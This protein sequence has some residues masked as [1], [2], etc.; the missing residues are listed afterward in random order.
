[1]NC[2]DVV[3]KTGE[4]LKVEI[5][6]QTPFQV[7]SINGRIG[8][9]GHS[10]SLI[11]KGT[12]D[13]IQREKVSIAGEQIFP[14]GDEFYD[15]DE[16][17]QGA[18]RYSSDFAHYKPR[19]D[20]LLVG[21]CHTPKGTI[22]SARQVTLKVG[23]K[24]KTLNVF[25]NRYWKRSI[26]GSSATEPEPFTE[27][28]LRYENSFGGRGYK[29]NPIGKGIDEIKLK[30]G[31]KV[32]L[33]PNVLRP[34]DQL[35]TLGSKSEPAGFGPIGQMW[36]DRFSKLGSYKGNYLKKRWPW[37][38]EDFDWS[39]FNA[40]PQDMQVEGYLKGDEELYFE[41]LHPEHPQYHSKLPGLRIRC[42]L[43]ESDTENENITHFREVSMN[44]D[45][46]WVDMENEKLVIVWRGVT[47]IK[48]EEYNEIQHIY[49][50]SENIEEQIQSID[51]YRMQFNQKISE[52][53]E[54]VEFEVE[55]PE[56]GEEAADKDIEKEIAKADAQMRASLIE[57][58]IDPD[59]PPPPSKEEKEKET[60]IMKELGIEDEEGEKPLTR[61]IVQEWISLGEGFA[62]EDLSGL[63]LS[64]LDM[65]GIDLKGAIL[66]GVSFKNAN[67]S[68]AKLMD[69]NLAKIDLSG[70]NMKKIDLKGADFTSANL[71]GADL[72]GATM[73]DTI[74][75]MARLEN[76]LLDGVIATDANFS[77]ANLNE[78]SLR[79]SIF[80][81]ADFS[82]C[83]MNNANFQGS[84]LREANLQ[85]AHGIKVNMSAT[86][87]TEL[88]ASEGCD[89][90]QGS[91]KKTTGLDSIWENA[92]LAEADFSFSHMEG[93]DFTSSNMKNAIFAC[94]NM[95]FAKLVK[96][97]LTCADFRKMNL[98]QGS[99]E[100]A[101]LTMTDLSG[102]N[103]Y[104]VEF[105][106]SIVERTN[107]EH[108]NL[109]MTKLS[110]MVV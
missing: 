80:Q 90:T 19:A 25:G 36:H 69:A 66:S 57:A 87:L 105:L 70:A 74:F 35:L 92:N 14:T 100:K 13:L 22:V 77:E 94:A 1:M 8:F 16:E 99:L 49:F 45:T 78:A 101:N 17:M 50:T 55:E 24:S 40:A 39:Y 88:R 56:I 26:L 73:G 43:N 15:D 38:P 98:F 37:F 53:E 106:E 11:V 110:H 29:K 61:E 79:D 63:D 46:L 85:G 32:C 107:L 81:G 34:D 12:F 76:A 72:T 58:G 33:L 44:P 9:P 89:F 54:E 48:S 51:H 109:K 31:K 3:N 62:G 27:I 108:T 102:S 65:Q 5:I 20:I 42:F 82:K 10:L 68:E 30:D 97:D 4:S 71:S 67:L 2:S 103:L 91:F 41:N 96:A 104:G 28:E 21:N 93:A 59:N 64:G 95:K 75:E 84:N 86:D 60:Q 6:N 52:M 7:A 23:P 83:V 47:A 18:V